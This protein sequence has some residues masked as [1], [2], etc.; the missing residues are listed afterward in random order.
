MK[1]SD[2]TEF[3]FFLSHPAETAC[4]QSLREYLENMYFAN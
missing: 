1:L 3:L 2:S 4:M